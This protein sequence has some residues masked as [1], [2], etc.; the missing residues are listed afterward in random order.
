M[1]QKIW[2]MA[3]ENHKAEMT[4]ITFLVGFISQVFVMSS[5]V[6]QA[7]AVLVAICACVFL[8]YRVSGKVKAS[9]EAEELDR[10]EVKE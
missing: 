8:I 1:L 7:G 9:L 4:A 10:K 2:H 6:L 3:W 5:D